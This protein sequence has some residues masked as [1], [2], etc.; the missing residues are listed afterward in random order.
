LSTAR[1][2]QVYQLSFLEMAATDFE[3]QVTELIARRQWD[4]LRH[5]CESAE[6]SV[7]FAIF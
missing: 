7:R 3:N 1:S 5:G 4:A 2:T 6:L